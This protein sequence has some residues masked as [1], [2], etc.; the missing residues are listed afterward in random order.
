M[1]SPSD[2]CWPHL[3]VLSALFDRH[4]DELRLNMVWL[5][6][7]FQSETPYFS[8]ETGLRPSERKAF[9][10]RRAYEG[11]NGERM[12]HALRRSVREYCVF[13]RMLAIVGSSK[14]HGLVGLATWDVWARG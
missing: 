2:G 11:A 1:V 9:L 4:G 14:H 6:L 3:D 10:E 8:F 13:P 12:C 7:I 5:D